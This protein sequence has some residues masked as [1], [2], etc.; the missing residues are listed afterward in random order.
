[1]YGLLFLC[2]LAVGLLLLLIP[3]RQNGA[4]P[5]TPEQERQAQRMGTWRLAALTGG[6]VLAGVTADLGAGITGHLLGLAAAVAF[7]AGEV[8]NP[9]RPAESCPAP[10]PLP[11]V[12]RV[13]RWRRGGMIAGFAAA[14][15]LF[16]VH[17]VQDAHSKPAF[18][19][20]GPLLGMCVVAAIL[21]SEL[22]IAAPGGTLRSARLK[23]RRI[24]DYVPLK[25]TLALTA[26]T[27]GF[28]LLLTGTTLAFLSATPRVPAEELRGHWAPYPPEFAFRCASGAIEEADFWGIGYIPW[29]L[30][31]AAT[32]LFLSLFALRRIVT[33]PPFDSG[34]A[35]QDADEK[36][37]EASARAVVQACGVLLTSSFAACAYFMSNAFSFTCQT[38][39]TLMLGNVMEALS[40]VSAAA[41]I[42]FLVSLAR[43]SRSPV[44]TR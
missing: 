2:S 44:V 23:H 12:Q 31:A 3:A 25:Q 13:R 21:T 16:L 8:V 34:P 33:R 41:L 27:A 22:L 28:L 42:F 1:M 24:R 5:L 20:M 32:G 39:R 7:T 40:Y 26:L 4:G 15:L 35:L 36:Q 38:P 6:L 37:R 43:A 19:L 11:A 10:S 18:L 30:S 9:V 14:G 17:S 29:I